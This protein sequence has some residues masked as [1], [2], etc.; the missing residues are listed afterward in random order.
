MD[1]MDSHCVGFITVHCMDA[2]PVR[3]FV[4]LLCQMMVTL[5]QSCLLIG[6]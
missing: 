6:G 5:K 1:L 3:V 2:R 4:I